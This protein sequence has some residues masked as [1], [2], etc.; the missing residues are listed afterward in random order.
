MAIVAYLGLAV[1]LPSKWAG[2]TRYCAV[3]WWSD[4][5]TESE[6]EACHVFFME[7]K[8]ACLEQL[9]TKAVLGI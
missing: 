3:S 9:L 2:N 8:K 4:G 5:L 6:F 7:A 1:Y